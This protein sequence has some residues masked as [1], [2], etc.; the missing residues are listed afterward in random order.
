MTEE[1]LEIIRNLLRE[2]KELKERL[3]LMEEILHSYLPVIGE[4]DE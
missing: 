2:N 4:N 3:N 1:F